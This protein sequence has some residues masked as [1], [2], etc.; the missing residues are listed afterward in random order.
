MV[1]TG[2]LI[3]LSRDNAKRVFAQGDDAGLISLL[4]ELKKSPELKKKGHVLDM[5]KAWDAI[6]RLL[7]EG[8]LEPNGG[9]FPLN[10]AILGGKPIHKG[11]DFAAVVVRPDMTPFVAEALA[12]VTQEDFQKKF[13]D[14]PGHG[15]NQGTTSK[16]FDEVWR[17]TRLLKDFYEFCAA[18]RLAVLFVG[19][20]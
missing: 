6:H 4:D 19:T 14:L 5:A 13:G 20:Y 3:A 10:T 7:T 12:E 18:E 8:T 9:D 15:Y 11:T 17:V 2:Y 1:G 16:D